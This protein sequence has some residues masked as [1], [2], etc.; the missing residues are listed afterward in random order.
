MASCSVGGL[1]RLRLQAAALAAVIL[2]GYVSSSSA[3]AVRGVTDTKIVIGTIAD[4][5]SLGAVQGVNSSDA[6][7]MVFDD[8][9]AKGGV[10][11]R[12]IKYIVEDSQS[13][14]SRAV[15]AM[16][17]LLNSDNVFIMLADGGTPMNDANMP[18]QFAKNVP[19]VFPQTA[20]RS[21]YEPYNR[22]KFAQFAS[23]YDQ[24]R[25]AVK[26]FAEQRGRKAFCGMYQDAG[27][28]TEVTAGVVA[29]TEAMGMKVVAATTHKPTDTD[30]NAPVAKLKEAGCD[31]IMLA[32]AV[33]D[34]NLIIQTARKMAWDVDLVGQF[35]SYDMAV[36][37]LPGGAAEGFFCMTPG[38]YAYP[39]DPNPV[40]QAFAKEYKRRYGRDPNYQG[41][42][43]YTAA[44][45]VLMALDRAGKDLTVDGFIRAMESIR[46]Y[47]D[48]FGSELSL[49]PDQHHGSTKSFL[50][51]VHDGRWVP[52]SQQALSY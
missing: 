2:F 36:A 50:S 3:E 4:L 28:G 37:G 49:G 14:V 30:F 17:K 43:G 16:N 41:E 20:A 31:A 27:M 35:V 33:R 22:L 18:Q 10:H 7:R 52:V 24:T 13:A 21:M 12:K 45:L 42:A 46:N 11:G 23:Y 40:V 48:I 51:V 32:T 39:D 9:N 1:A 38:L 25:S 34:S 47:K 44:N 8:R 26:Y 29:Q 6:I 15:Q 5:S 19:N